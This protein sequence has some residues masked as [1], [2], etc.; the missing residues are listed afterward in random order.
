MPQVLSN[1]KKS[2]SISTYQEHVNSHKM[3]SVKRVHI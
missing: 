2:G 3:K 1:F